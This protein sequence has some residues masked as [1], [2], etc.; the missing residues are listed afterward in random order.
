MIESLIPTAAAA[1]TAVASRGADYLKRGSTR[2]TPSVPDTG[3]DVALAVLAI[4]PQLFNLVV[5]SPLVERFMPI[6]LSLLYRLYKAR[7]YLEGAGAL[8]LAALTFRQKTRDSQGKPLGAAISVTTAT[9]FLAQLFTPPIAFTPHDGHLVVTAKEL[10]R[11]LEPDA[12]VLGLFLNGDAR[13]YPLE[14]LRKPHL[15]HDTVGGVPVVPT[16]CEFTRSALAFRDD[17]RGERMDLQVVAFPNNNVVFYERHSDGMIQQLE[18][19]I[20]AGPN[21]GDPLQVFPLMVTTWKHWQDLH[22]QTTGLW[23]EQNVKG[24]ALQYVMEAIERMDG[25]TDQPLYAVQGGPDTRLAPKEPVLAVRVK[26]RSKAY[27]RVYLQNNPVVNDEL[28]GEPIV[29]LYDPQRDVAGVYF[30][31]LDDRVLS[32]QPVEHGKGVAEDQT[33]GLLWDVAGCAQVG[34][35]EERCLKPVPFSLDGVR[36]FAWAHF[37]PDTQIA[38]GAVESKASAP[39]SAQE[40]R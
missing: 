13:C 8:A 20:G 31:R 24:G 30:R 35:K 27:T 39:G 21:T 10:N 14:I 11:L 25:R 15:I 28:A 37:Y 33:D 12:P 17:W 26:G 4:A 19:T 34:R 2:L 6:K 40:S 3:L 9:K 1:A 36:W 29:V 32:F 22:P 18:A 23:Y 38:R 5:P 16:Y 7:P